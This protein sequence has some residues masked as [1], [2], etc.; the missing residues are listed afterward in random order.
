M[1]L[2]SI[3]LPNELDRRLADE[4]R[5][6]RKTRSNLAREAIDAFLAARRREEIEA[7]LRKAGAMSSSEDVRIAEEALPYGNEALD[8]GEEPQPGDPWPPKW[9]R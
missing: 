4:A 7:M 2:L 8:I 6:A 9:W 5:R 1:K 3:R